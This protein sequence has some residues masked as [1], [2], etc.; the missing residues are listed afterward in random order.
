MRRETGAVQNRLLNSLSPADRDLLLPEGEAF[1]LDRGDV[2]FDPGEN[3]V[4]VYFPGEGTIASFLMQLDDGVT[5]EA[6]MIGC[7]GAVGG[8]VSFGRKPAFAQA[9]VQISGSALRISTDVVEAAKQR[10][11]SLRDHFA[12]Y[13]DC[14]LAQVVQSVA[15]NAAHDYEARLARWL[16]A[17]RD[18]IGG[19]ELRVTHQFVSEMLGVQRSYTSRVLSALEKEGAI[20]TGRGCIRITDSAALQRR[21]C[22]CYGKLREHFDRLLP[23]VLA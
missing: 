14:L 2:L 4:N 20:E 19:H 15:C 6:A 10:S 22:E 7:E 13:A 12:R 8:I 9:I 17:T 3:V 1:H 16:L 21:A 5:T 18:R 11:D 23:G